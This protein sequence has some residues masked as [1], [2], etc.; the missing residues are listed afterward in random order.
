MKHQSIPSLNGIRAIAVLLVF[1]SHVGF[2]HVI[3]GGFGVTT[4]FFL[5]G[6]LITTLLLNEHETSGTIALKL[7]FARRFLRLVP[8]LAI[9]LLI[10]YTLFFV[11]ALQGEFSSTGVFCQL[12]YLANYYE[13]FAWGAAYPEGMGIY[14]SLAVEEHFYLVFPVLL[15]ICIRN[16]SL[17]TTSAIF[18][19]ICACILIWRGILALEDSTSFLRT[20]AAT[21]TRLDSILFGCTLALYLKRKPERNEKEL[22]IAD[23]S[24]L[25]TCATTLII[26]F[27]IQDQFFKETL[28]YSIQGLAL[29]PLFYYSIKFSKHTIFAWLN[30]SFFNT[31]GVY[32]YFIYLIH[33]IVIASLQFYY[34]SITTLEL[35]IYALILSTSYAAA[36]DKL[37]DSHLKAIRS[38][39]R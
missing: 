28:R 19:A 9:T 22:R 29:T 20:Y 6:F 7:F 37:L 15:L 39:L 4:F 13:V 18:S 23:W 32:S 35:T 11:G 31:L 14:W 33:T 27:L 16:Y 1:F 5:S 26:T 3:P 8:P 17:Q 24:V 30:W 36:F 10:G 38:K 12:F 25:L 21:D 34:P 2:G